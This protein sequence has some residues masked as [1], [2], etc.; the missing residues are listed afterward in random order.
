MPDISR[1][2]ITSVAAIVIFF[3][4]YRV[5][6]L[7][8]SDYYLGAYFSGD[9]AAL[10]KALSWNDNN[11]KALYLISKEAIRLN[12]PFTAAEIQ[13]S[14]YE[15]PADARAILLT[16]NNPSA[17]ADN[18]ARDQLYE[19]AVSLMPAD[20]VVRLQAAAHWVSRD[21]L[22]RAV[23]NWSTA[24]SIDIELGD[25]LYP[26]FMQIAQSEQARGQLVSLTNAPPSWWNDF[27]Q[28]LTVNADSTDALLEIM[29]MRRQSQVA[30]ST[31]ERES[32]VRRLMKESQWAAAYLLWVEGLALDDR[33]FLGM[34][35]DGNFESLSRVYGF[36]WQFSKS[37]DI[38]T[39]LQRDT[40]AL[41][42][43]SLYLRFY[44]K[45][46]S[47]QHV[48]QYLLLAPGSYEFQAST[49]TGL[50]T[51]RG[52]LKWFI[53]CA[54]GQRD[55]LGNSGNIKMSKEWSPLEFSFQ[56]PNDNKCKA[57]LLRLE[58]A[59][60]HL[61]DHKL[62]GELWLDQVSITRQKQAS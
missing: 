31:K 10:V 14:I 29:K 38:D 1:S 21:L 16:A 52:R 39:I 53:R 27:I 7:G 17:A 9:D 15:N 12:K 40:T 58:T 43:K 55:I 19:R 20:K 35:Y 5:F 50:L 33:R 8:F 41:G 6:S 61:F 54:D 56:V 28:Y 51:G 57:Q 13:K 32:V 36:D 45:E 34:V 47:F 25:A 44:N 42:K 2:A 62:K 49:R 48:Y 30:I 23:N 59:G 37:R 22:D 18:D 26:V 46:M 3:I 11:P 24:L 4:I 60:K